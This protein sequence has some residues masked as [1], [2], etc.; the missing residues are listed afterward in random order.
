MS[1]APAEIEELRLVFPGVAEA[2]EGG[3][4]Y[5][6]IPD[7]RLPAGTRPERVHA[8]LCPRAECHGYPSRLFFSERLESNKSLNWNPA[9]G[10][11]ILER[12]W[13]AFSWRL[14]QTGLRLVQLVAL[15]LKP[16][17]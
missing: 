7:L 6:L 1:C 2:L 12:N 3:V 15:H 17:Q 10:I 14:N 5:V 8:L 13:H 11:R 16:L 4:G 9:N